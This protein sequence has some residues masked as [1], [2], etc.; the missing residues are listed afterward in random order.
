MLHHL[1]IRNELAEET[2]HNIRDH[3]DH[4]KAKNNSQSFKFHNYAIVLK[5]IRS[6]IK[7]T[8]LQIIPWATIAN[9]MQTRSLIDCKNKFMQLLEIVFREHKA[10]QE[11]II[12]FI[13]QQAVSEEGEI[14]WLQWQ[15]EDFTLQEAKNR[16]FFLK[17][18][19]ADRSHKTFTV[20][21]AELK[22]KMKRNGMY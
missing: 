14:D 6:P 19:I 8:P 3:I 1:D 2:A 12:T 10:K 17:K 20:L 21:L 22:A 5:H 13:E 18:I 15:R 16:F 4:L 11:S 7:A 9:K